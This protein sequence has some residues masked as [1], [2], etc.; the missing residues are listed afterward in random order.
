MASQNFAKKNPNLAKSFVNLRLFPI[1]DI[2]E[3]RLKM[4]LNKLTRDKSQKN[5]PQKVI[6]STGILKE[7]F[8]KILPF[9]SPFC[10]FFEK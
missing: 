10:K 2:S 6:S 8:G 7:N 9:F 4:C 1:L 3:Y 5:M